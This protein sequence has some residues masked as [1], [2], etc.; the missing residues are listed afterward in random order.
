MMAKEWGVGN[1]ASAK[2]FGTTQVG[3]QTVE[4]ILGE[5]PH[6]RQDSTTYARW[7]DGSIEGFN[8]HRVLKRI[9]VEEGNYLKTSGLSG[10]EVRR[11]CSCKI[12]F[13]DR[14]VYE[15]AGRDLAPMLLRIHRTISE[16]L[17][18]PV[19]LAGN[20][21]K[22]LI[23]RKIYYHEQPAVIIHFFPD[24]GA[25]V[26]QADGCTFREPAWHKDKDDPHHEYPQENEDQEVKDDILSPHIWW[27][28]E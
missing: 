9:E 12:F 6:S 26:M 7:P 21:D 22:E 20:W 15:L 27:F 14:Q 10:N 16:L 8:G 24:Q 18:L 28:R 25:I 5:H 3:G 2:A 19:N 23:G 17:E 1:Q 13:N 4:L 11:T